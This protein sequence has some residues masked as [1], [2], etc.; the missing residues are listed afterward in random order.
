MISRDVV[1][2]IST[3]SRRLVKLESNLSSADLLTV[4][5]Y[6]AYHATTRPNDSICKQA[7]NITLSSDEQYR[8]ILG[9]C[10]Y[11]LSQYGFRFSMSRSRELIPEDFNFED[12]WASICQLEARSHE[13]S[14]GPALNAARLMLTVFYGMFSNSR[15]FPSQRKD[16]I[17]WTF[18]W[19]PFSSDN[20]QISDLEYKV[21]F[22]R[23]IYLYGRLKDLKDPTIAS[24]SILAR[25]E[26]LVESLKVVRE[27][28][29]VGR[30]M[31]ELRLAIC[32]GLARLA[33]LPER[34]YE[35]AKLA[36]NQFLALTSSLDVVGIFKMRSE[37]ILNI[38]VRAVDTREQAECQRFLDILEVDKVKMRLHLIPTRKDP[39]HLME[40]FKDLY[41]QL[42]KPMITEKRMKDIFSDLFSPWPPINKVKILDELRLITGLDYTNRNY[43]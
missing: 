28:L 24:V 29:K 33:V 3:G 4:L 16:I 22:L 21:A 34:P 12:V 13:S 19:Q 40:K 27:S 38:C 37:V 35:D 31:E 18:Q 30:M 15:H 42:Q 2:H 39:P 9:H 43:R 25:E 7:R 1:P 23:P 41:L 26:Q 17:K 11:Y 14:F 8:E 10:R 5:S 20:T 32:E 36:V 6:G